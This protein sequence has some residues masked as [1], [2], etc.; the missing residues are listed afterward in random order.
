MDEDVSG[1]FKPEGFA[2]FYEL[3][4]DA[5][6]VVFFYLGVCVV[7]EPQGAFACECGVI[8]VDG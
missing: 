5:V 8:E 3:V 7:L 6:N 4:S 1:G 2:N